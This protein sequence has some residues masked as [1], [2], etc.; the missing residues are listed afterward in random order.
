[1]AEITTTQSFS[2]GDTVTATKLNNIQG[3]ASIQPEAITNR[4]LETTV[5]QAN[6]L[7]LIYDASSTSLNKVSPS[8]LI[9]AGTASDFPIGGNATI[10]GTLGVTGNSTLGGTLG[11]TGAITATSTINGTTIPTTK[12]L[13]T[14]VDTQTLTNKTLTTPVISSI[15]NTGTLTLPT[16]TDTLVGRATTDT[17]TNKTLTS[18]SISDPTI[19]GQITASTSIINVGSGQIFKDATGNVGVG[20]A[21]PSQKLDVDG[22]VAARGTLFLGNGSSSV[23]RKLNASTPL[24]IANSGGAAEMTIDSSGRVGIG[25]S[26]PAHLLD[27]AA[28]TPVARINATGGGTPSLSLFSSGVYEWLL[29]GG[30]ALKFVQDTTERLRIDSSGNVGIGGTPSAL[31]HIQATSP[32][33]RIQAA[34]GNSSAID[35]YRTA[36]VNSGQIACESTNSLVFSTNTGSALVERL[37]IASAG[38]IGIGGANYGTSGQVLASGGASAAPSWTTISSTPAD[39]SITFAKLSTSSTEGENAAKRVAKVWVNYNGTTAGI[40]DDFNV[41][42]ITDNAEGDQTVNFSSSLSSA[43]YCAV[44]TVQGPLE[45]LYSSML[46]SVSAPATGSV[47]VRTGLRGVAFADCPTVNVCIFL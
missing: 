15:T 43:S 47:R 33:L 34:S 6:D 21:S 25:T 39:G 18:P 14:T 44:T 23:I 28:T 38:Q 5:D 26:S 9:K 13:V 8:N 46:T 40:R 35:F 4:S 31:L 16:S 20:T 36:S 30:T 45:D 1:M 7:L 27:V 42:S 24:T 41:S 2:D 10:G 37:R 19:T 32:S 22:G 29:Q 11:V 3:N 17:L 12:T